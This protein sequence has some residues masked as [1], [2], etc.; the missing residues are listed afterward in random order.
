MSDQANILYCLEECRES[1]KNEDFIDAAVNAYWCIK[2]CEQ[3]EP[4]GMSNRDLSEAESEAS[5][6]LHDCYKKFKSCKLSK[7]TFMYGTFCPKLLW[8]YK[9]KYNARSLS[10]VTRNRFDREHVVGALARKLFP[11]GI[12]A[13]D[14]NSEYIIDMS[15]FRL[16]FYLNQH[17]WLNITEKLYTIYT[18]YEAAFVYN[19]VFAA[20]DILENNSNEYTAYEVKSSTTINKTIL[21][22][23][24]LQY[25]VISNNCNL[26]DFFL[27]YVN[28][29]YLDELQIPFEEMNGSNIDINRLF[30]KESV[31]SRILPLQDEI[32]DQIEYCKSILSK[33]E[34]AVEM[35]SQCSSPHECMFAHYCKYGES[36]FDIWQ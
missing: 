31:L 20:V 22:D 34:P 36:E 11:D 16:P 6:I 24:A 1:Y 23:C 14:F 33:Q 9:N 35:G 4:Y 15:R 28:G 5:T 21:Q 30:I 10:S 13:S 27:L 26:K 25:Y 7:T 12:D 29:Q 18:V 17:N 32:R 2:Y 3:G 19:D 8:L